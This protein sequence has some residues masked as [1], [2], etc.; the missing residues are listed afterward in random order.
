MLWLYQP[1]YFDAPS[2]NTTGN[3]DTPRPVPAFTHKTF[4]DSVICAADVRQTSST[5]KTFHTLLAASLPLLLSATEY[6]DTKYHTQYL[7]RSPY[8]INV[9]KVNTR[10]LS[11]SLSCHRTSPTSNAQLCVRHIP[12]LS[13]QSIMFLVEH[14]MVYLVKVTCF[15]HIHLRMLPPSSRMRRTRVGL[16]SPTDTTAAMVHEHLCQC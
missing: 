10:F 7:D 15:T 12:Q 9:L 5:L 14:R 2:H 1:Y 8:S 13:H 4:V 16:F 6:R 3:N 11:D